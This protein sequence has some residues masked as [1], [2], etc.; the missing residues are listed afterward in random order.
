[1]VLDIVILNHVRQNCERTKLDYGDF[2]ILR[3]NSRIG[4]D[5]LGVLKAF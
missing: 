4:N 2:E 5:D 1:M 3:N